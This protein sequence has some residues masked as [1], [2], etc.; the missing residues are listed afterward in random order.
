[1]A[2]FVLVHGAYHGAWCWEELVPELERLGH[3][4]LAIDLPGNG[5][6]PTPADQVSLAAY[7]ERVGSA[8]NRFDD[9]AWLVG[10]S[11]GGL[12]ITASGEAHAERLEGLIYV[13]ALV[14]KNGES[15]ASARGEQPDQPAE[16]PTISTGSAPCSTTLASRTTSNALLPSS[17]RF[18][19]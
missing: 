14:T 4:A 1:M 10:H 3:R 9:K 18:R 2:T 16:L 5:P 17:I 6:D 15:F 13:T 11:L 12:T 19:T 7:V 8:L